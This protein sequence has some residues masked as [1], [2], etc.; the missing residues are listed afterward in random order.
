MDDAW[1]MKNCFY[2][3]LR[4]VTKWVWCEAWCWVDYELFLL[5]GDHNCAVM[6][7]QLDKQLERW[8]EHR[9]QNTDLIISSWN[10]ANEQKSKTRAQMM[11]I[12]ACSIFIPACSWIWNCIW[13]Y[14]WNWIWNVTTF[15]KICFAKFHIRI[16]WNFISC[17]I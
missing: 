10:L 9:T 16:I 3:P 12:S 1:C 15:V 13:N 6:F 17:F 2:H 8:Q 11:M 7:F 5:V 4:W 14:I